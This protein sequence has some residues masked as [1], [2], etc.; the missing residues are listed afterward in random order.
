[1]NVLIIIILTW[2]NDKIL[3]SISTYTAVVRITVHLQ[4]YFII[5]S[6]VY[7][8]DSTPCFIRFNDV[9]SLKMVPLLYRFNLLLSS[10][11]E[12][13]AEVAAVTQT[14][15]PTRFTSNSIVYWNMPALWHFL[16][17]FSIWIVIHYFVY[18]WCIFTVIPLHYISVES[19]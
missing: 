8:M 2:W 19:R 6:L 13:N 7:N 3:T 12:P 5:R 16:R 4:T 15:F 18:A 17:T 1:M 9:K 10:Q 14:I 11:L